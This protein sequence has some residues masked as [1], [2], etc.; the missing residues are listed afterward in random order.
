MQGYYSSIK[1]MRVIIGLHGN[2]FENSN[3][4]SK[5]YSYITWLSNCTSVIKPNEIICNNRIYTFTC[6]SSDIYNK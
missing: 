3:K 2:E 5:N 6:T 1:L 4:M